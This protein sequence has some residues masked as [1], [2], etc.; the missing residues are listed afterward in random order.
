MRPHLTLMRPH[1]TLMMSLSLQWQSC[2][3]GR[4]HSL[5]VCSES[6]FPPSSC[7][8]LFSFPGWL[9]GIFSDPGQE[10]CFPSAFPPQKGGNTLLCSLS[11]PPC[12]SAQCLSPSPY[13]R[14]SR[15]EDCAR[16]LFC[17]SVQGRCSIMIIKPHWPV[18]MS[19]RD[20][21]TQRNQCIEYATKRSLGEGAEG[22]EEAIPSWEYLGWEHG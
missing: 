13:C 12:L 11:P 6:S 17:P 2:V 4:S 3:L 8:Y 16:L 9:L 10:R 14:S 1:L 18:H 15:A 20:W 7:L 22:I 5:I 21:R 19:P